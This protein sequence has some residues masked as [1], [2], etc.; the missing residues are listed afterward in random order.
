[1]KI[2]GPDIREGLHIFNVDVGTVFKYCGSFYVRTTKEAWDGKVE[3]FDIHNCQVK[4]LPA[5]DKVFYYP[6]AELHLGLER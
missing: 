2:L 6:E 5:W 4:I 3:A 1:M